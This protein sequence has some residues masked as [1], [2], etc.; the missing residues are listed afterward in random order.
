MALGCCGR[1]DA[2]EGGRKEAPRHGGPEQQAVDSLKQEK[3]KDKR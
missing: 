2:A 3:L 1:K